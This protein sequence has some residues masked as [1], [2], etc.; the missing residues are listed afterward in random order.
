M[1]KVFTPSFADEADTNAQNLSVKEV[2]CRLDPSA[3]EV[4]MLHEGRP[5]SRITSR[6]NTRLL[7]WRAH[8]NTLRIIFDILAKAPDVYFFPREGPLDAAFLKVRRYFRLK[9]ALV[10]YVISG[11]LDSGPYP[12]AREQ[13]IRQA[14]LVFDNNAHLGQLLRE[15]MGIA[16]AGTI[17]D[18]IDRRY[19]FC[20]DDGRRRRPQ[21]IVLFAGSF[22]PYKRVPLVVRQAAGWPNVQFRIAGTGE[23]EQLCKK[24]AAESGCKNVHFLGHLSQAQ[25]GEEMR[26]ADIFFFPSVLEGHPQVLLQAA[27]CGLPAVAMRIYRPDSVVDGQTGFLADGDEDLSFKLDQLIRNPEL[28]S[29]MSRAAAAH[30]RKFDWDM[31]AAKWSQAFEQVVAKRGQSLAW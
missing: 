2:V 24:L 20:P 14:D 1:I 3:F 21:I 25:L 5:D 10:S 7:A 8:G 28:R 16:S 23:E 19:F 22:R 11:G 15:K 9:T 26:Q 13:Q 4:T 17:H 27:G 18:G 31:I 6:P 30:A 12:P 29:C